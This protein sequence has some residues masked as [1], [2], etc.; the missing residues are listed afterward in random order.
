MRIAG[1]LDTL[2]RDLRFGVRLLRRSPGFT[3]VAALSLALGIGANTA[4]FQL[5]DAVR[6][7]S[8]PV[9]DPGQLV[10]VRLDNPGPRPGNVVARYAQLT[11]PQWERLGADQQAFSSLLAWSPSRFNLARGGEVRNA[12][13]MFVSGSFFEVL[14]VP[15]ARGRVLGAADDQRGCGSRAAVISCAFWQREDGGGP[16]VV[17]RAI[18]LVALGGGPPASRLVDRRGGGAPAD[19]IPRALRG[20]AAGTAGARAGGQVPEV[21]A[22]RGGLRRRLLF[23]AHAVRSAALAAPGPVRARPVHGVRQHR[24][25]APGASRRPHAR[26]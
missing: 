20:D 7:R 1:V 9:K 22:G 21:Q 11:Y 17:G 16:T 8:L 12:Q 5:L 10:E 13:G 18:H 4:I 6:L 2:W 15:A 23:A 26:A 14:G 24:E 3:T 25:P 19:D